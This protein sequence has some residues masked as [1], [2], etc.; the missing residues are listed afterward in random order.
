M[1]GSDNGKTDGDM[2]NDKEA[3]CGVDDGSEERE[4]GTRQQKESHD[5]REPEEST[6][7]GPR[8]DGEEKKNAERRWRWRREG[9]DSKKAGRVV[10]DDGKLQMEDERMAE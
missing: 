5:D 9:G 6:K 2:V 10:R 4:S 1:E 7:E 3:G 8:I